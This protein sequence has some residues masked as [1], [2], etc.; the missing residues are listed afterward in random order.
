M[1]RFLFLQ[2]FLLFA[3]G[4]VCAQKYEPRESWPYL[5]ENF[6]TGAV[7]TVKGSLIEDSTY[8]ISIADG[9]LHYIVDGKIMKIDMM[10][11]YTARVGDQV[12]VNVGGK[13]YQVLAETDNG[14][15]IQLVSID[16]DK[17]GKVDIGYGI[18]SSSAS[19]MNVTSLLQGMDSMVNTHFDTAIEKRDNGI[20]LPLLAEKFIYV[21]GKLVPASKYGVREF[22]GIDKAAANAFF[23]EKNIKWN[24][25]ESLSELIDFV[26]GQIVK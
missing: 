13:M 14:S 19:A 20:E 22:P 24:K 8:N 25:D 1:K 6:Q 12:F 3:A 4:T 26:Y 21:D 17:L 2:V 18:S 16:F 23:K 15:L 5:N 11:I 10:T 7:R 9:S